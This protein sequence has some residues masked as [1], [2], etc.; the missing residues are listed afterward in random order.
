[1]R[2]WGMYVQKNVWMSP[3]SR[4]FRGW[5]VIFLILHGTLFTS[6]TFSRLVVP[7]YAENIQYPS[8]GND[9]SHTE[10]IIYSDYFCPACLILDSQLSNTL[11]NLENQVKI[12]FVDVP[13]HP[14]SLEFAKVFLYTW[15]ESGNN[16]ERA[17]RVRDI[18]FREAKMRMSHRKV[19]RILNVQG[20]PYKQDEETANIIFRQINNPLMKMDKIHATP[21]MV[22]VKGNK[23]QSY[24]G[25][26]EILKAIEELTAHP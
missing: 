16:L 13:L 8:F 4:H 3:A 25:T 21:T 11:R 19:M 26:V 14:G 2:N 17:M 18:L 9:K 5:L 6:F 20:I 15:F 24:T 12:R 22:I 10:I 1:M 23:R 7:A